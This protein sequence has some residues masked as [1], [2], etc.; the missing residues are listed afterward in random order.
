MLNKFITFALVMAVTVGVNAAT[1]ANSLVW[2]QT[3]PDLATAQSYTYKYYLDGAVTGF[4]F[5]SVTCAAAGAQLFTC[6][7]VFPNFTTGNHTIQVSASNSVG[8]SLKSSPFAFTF[9][10]NPSSPVMPANIRII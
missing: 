1:T 3:A 4:V 9:S 5:T 6:Q 8:E 10:T 7:N 2:D